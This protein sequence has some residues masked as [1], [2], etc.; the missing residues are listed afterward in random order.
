MRKIRLFETAFDIA[1]WLNLLCR[2]SPFLMDNILYTVLLELVVNISVPKQTS[3]LCC[4]SV[5][6]TLSVY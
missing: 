2:V 6:N 1:E 4:F 5:K 3:F